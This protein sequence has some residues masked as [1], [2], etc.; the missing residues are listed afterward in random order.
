MRNIIKDQ[1]ALFFI[2]LWFFWTLFYILNVFL[3]FRNRYNLYIKCR[4]PSLSFC[5]SLGQ[6]LVVTTLTWKIILLPQNYPTIIETWLVWFFIPLHMF[7]Y[8]TRSLRFILKYNLQKY[9][10]QDESIK[11]KKNIIF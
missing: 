4:F 3:F 5:S 11:K 9:D 10:A 2:T 7:P 6:Y 1:H 8:L